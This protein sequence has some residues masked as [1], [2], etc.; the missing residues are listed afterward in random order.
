M[1]K[2]IK[3]IIESLEN[4]FIDA[5]N[6]NFS[7]DKDI[8]ILDISFEKLQILLYLLHKEYGIQ[9]TDVCDWLYDEVYHKINL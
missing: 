9:N 6:H 4:C 5:D 2:D 1:E 7:L 8:C 3:E